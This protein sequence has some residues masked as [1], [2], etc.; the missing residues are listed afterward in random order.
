MA[1][2]LFTV[3]QEIGPIYLDL[4]DSGACL[5]ASIDIG[6]LTIAMARKLSGHDRKPIALEPPGAH[7]HQFVMIFTCGH[8]LHSSCQSPMAPTAG[9]QAFHYSQPNLSMTCLEPAS[10]VTFFS[11]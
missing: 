10:R 4:R 6:L 9:G 7:C 11:R 1:F 8:P 2:R 3:G 5:T